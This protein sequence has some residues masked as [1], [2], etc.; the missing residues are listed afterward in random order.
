[1]KS[2]SEMLKEVTTE[3]MAKDLRD[4]DVRVDGTMQIPRIRIVQKRGQAGVPSGTELG[5]FYSQNMG[6]VNPSKSLDIVIT[7]VRNMR[8][9]W[10]KWTDT[11]KYIVCRCTNQDDKHG[12]PS[13]RTDDGRLV[14]GSEKRNCSYCPHDWFR[15]DKS[16]PL[17]P[18]KANGK[19]LEEPCKSEKMFAGFLLSDGELDP[20][21]A[22]PFFMSVGSIMFCKQY[23]ARTDSWTA[24]DGAIKMLRP[25]MPWWAYRLR[26]STDIIETASGP[27][28]APV[29]EVIGSNVGM[30]D[31][32]RNVIEHEYSGRLSL[33]GEIQDVN[34]ILEELPEDHSESPSPAFTGPKTDMSDIPI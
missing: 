17:P 15:E 31:G 28:F 25:A 4:G 7:S 1:M 18:L 26:M 19:V 21:S 16:N 13:V 9:V 3:E 34:D 5:D 2:I 30:F 24:F 20:K 10:T 23:L 22:V 11:N 27:W 33:T 12:F 8:R 14:Q 32:I 6:F 29:F